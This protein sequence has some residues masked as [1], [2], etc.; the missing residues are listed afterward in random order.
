MVKILFKQNIRKLTVFPHFPYY[1]YYE[2]MYL[3]IR[4]PIYI[5]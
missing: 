2:H 5:F 4:V 3:N 1:L